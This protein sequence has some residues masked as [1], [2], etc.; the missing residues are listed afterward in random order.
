M[1]SKEE[2][3]MKFDVRITFQPEH[4]EV[5]AKDEDEAIEKAEEEWYDDKAYPETEDVE[6]WGVSGERE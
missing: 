3:L 2:K 6:I 5:E 4:I 1:K